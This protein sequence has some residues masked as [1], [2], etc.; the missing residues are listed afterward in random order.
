VAGIGGK[1]TNAGVDHGGS[2]ATRGGE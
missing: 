1:L 2:P